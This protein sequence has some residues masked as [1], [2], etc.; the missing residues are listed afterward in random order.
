MPGRFGF[1]GEA[2][3]APGR[4]GSRPVRS[5]RGIL[6]IIAGTWRGRILRAPKGRSVRP[7]LDRVREA[8]F[9]ILGDRVAGARVLDLFA[10]SGAMALEALSRGA[11][12]AVLVEAEP[13]TFAVLRRNVESL[14]ASSAEALPLDYR[15]AARRLKARGSR[16]E[17]VF[18]DPPY[19]LG[20]AA[21]AAAE[22]DGAGLVSPGAAVVVEEAARA[23][24][25]TFPGRWEAVLDRTY[26]QTRIVVFDVLPA[27]GEGALRG[28]GQ[29][30]ETRG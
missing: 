14:G 3:R 21:A 22:I 8:V 28:P 23:P 27:S 30:K 19:G 25:G 15:A 12:R 16:F 1:P 11:A 18:L 7:T 10:G 20:M 6:R 13:R 17:V 26:G 29:N 2:R 24:A 4:G 9:S 5:A